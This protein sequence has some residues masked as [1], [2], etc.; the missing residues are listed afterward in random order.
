MVDGLEVCVVFLCSP[1]VSESV[2]LVETRPLV[3]SGSRQ[4]GVTSGGGPRFIS[5]CACFGMDAVAVV[6]VIPW[7]EML[8]GATGN[9]TQLMFFLPGRGCV[10]RLA[11]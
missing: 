8:S 11:S 6:P 7:H 5:T 1:A 2:W 3:R 9:V 10:V 4:Q